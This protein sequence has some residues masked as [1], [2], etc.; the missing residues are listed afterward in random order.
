MSSAR[1]D[2]EL[3]FQN[4]PKGSRVTDS[5]VQGKLY[6]KVPE[7]PTRT[8]KPMALGFQNLHHA[9]W[10]SIT[11]PKGSRGQK[12]KKDEFPDSGSMGS[13]ILPLAWGPRFY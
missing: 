5:E 8:L 6:P 1:C 2:W 13:S 7:L 4:H 9:F 12:F 3:R 11:I 10:F